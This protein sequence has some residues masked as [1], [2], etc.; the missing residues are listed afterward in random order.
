MGI[1]LPDPEDW[2]YFVWHPW[3]GFQ[4]REVDPT[5]FEHFVVRNEQYVAKHQGLLH[6]F[7]DVKEMSLKDLYQ[8]HPTKP[9][10]WLYGGRTDDMI[11][12][13]SGEKAH[14]TSIEAIINQHP[15]I[16]SSLMVG[17]GCSLKG[18]S[19]GP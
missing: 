8:P 16:K 17:N 6:T 11:V 1:L 7:S 14:P 18:K 5:R 10:L 12:L 3:A 15:A 13:S 19:D 9:G 2:I 4:F